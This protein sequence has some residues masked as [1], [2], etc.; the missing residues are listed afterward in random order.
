MQM[1][2]IRNKNFPV[3]FDFFVHVFSPIQKCNV[4][5]AR[6]SNGSAG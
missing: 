4:K 5:L 1:R 6:T 3:R 2:L